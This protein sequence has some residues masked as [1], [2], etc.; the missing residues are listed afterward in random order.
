LS[1]DIKDDPDTFLARWSDR[2]AAARRGQALPEPEPPAPDDAAEEGAKPAVAEAKPAAPLE[3][4]PLESLD[5][6]SDYSPF[7]SEGVSETLKRAA[8][9]KLFHTASFNVTDGLDD[10]D[11]DFRTFKS[12]G[13]VVTHE[14][15]RM[16]KI[17]AEREKEKQAEIARAGEAHAS[18]PAEPEELV[19]SAQQAEQPEL[20]Q[21]P[22][23][24][25]GQDQPTEEDHSDDDR[26]DS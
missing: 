9:R 13:D 21:G 7:F 4:P 8:L 22:D 3:L 6:N 11:E 19:E 17:E 16:A 15:K 20:A 25:Q 26:R 5:E 1:R 14:M 10:Y 18:R 12:L 2:K 23:L 24:T